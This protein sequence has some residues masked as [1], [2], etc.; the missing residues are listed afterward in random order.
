MRK[1]MI[2]VRGIGIPFSSLGM[3]DGFPHFVRKSLVIS[4]TSVREMVPRRI[5]AALIWFFLVSCYWMLLAIGC[6]H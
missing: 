5:R 2:L 1:E 6:W 3:L 4:R